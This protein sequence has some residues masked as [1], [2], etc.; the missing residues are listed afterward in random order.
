MVNTLG[1]LGTGG[2][3]CSDPGNNVRHNQRQ[4]LDALHKLNYCDRE[5]ANST[6]RGG[7]SQ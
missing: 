1:K 3:Q 2:L 5:R 6:Q 7:H 4:V